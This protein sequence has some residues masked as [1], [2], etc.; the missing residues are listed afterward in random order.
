MSW[1]LRIKNGDLSVDGGTY[2]SITGPEKLVQDLRCWVLEPQGNDVMHPDYGSILLGGVS[3]NGEQI[4]SPVGG[5]FSAEDLLRIE[6]EIRRVI[7]AYQGQQRD[8]LAMDTVRYGGKNTMS[9]GEILL[10]IR[11]ISIIQSADNALCFVS[12]VTGNGDVLA[13]TV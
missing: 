10:S 3:P 2:D 11:N 9:P 13:F 7:A 5:Y 1:S 8:R 4:P 12:L 6:S